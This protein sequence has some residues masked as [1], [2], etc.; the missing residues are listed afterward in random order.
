MSS[1]QPHT[2]SRQEPQHPRPRRLISL[3]LLA[4]FSALIYGYLWWGRF[5]YYDEWILGGV[6]VGCL[7]LLL[8]HLI[9]GGRRHSLHRWLGLRLDNLSQALRLAL[10]LT[11]AMAAAALVVAW[12]SGRLQPEQERLPWV[13]IPWA[14][15]Q[16]FVLQGFLLPR[17]KEVLGS[18]GAAIVA[19]AAL[20]GLYHL[21]NWP[22]MAASFL[23]G[24][25]WCWIFTRR[26][27][28][29]AVAISHALLGLLISFF[30]KFDGLQQFRVGKGGHPYDNFGAGVT[31]AA[32]YDASNQPFIAALPGPDIDHPCRVRLFRPD[33]ELLRE[34]EAFPS[35]GYSC[36]VAAGD[37]DSKPGD[38]IALA[39]GPGVR[40]PSQVRV[41]D[42]EGR[43]MERF[44]L[45]EGGYGAWVGIGRGR[46]T[47]APGPGPEAPKRVYEYSLDEGLLRTWNL[48]STD[49][50]NALRASPL[51]DPPRLLVWPTPV[52]VNHGFVYVFSSD[53][54][55]PLRWQAFNTD[56][57]L[58]LA[59]LRLQSGGWGVVTAPGAL[60]GHPPHIR[61]Y[62]W[63]GQ[64]Q[65]YFYAE[66]RQEDGCG[67]NLAAVDVD[68]DGFDEIIMADGH[69]PGAPATVRVFTQQGQL[70]HRFPAF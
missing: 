53:S 28:L 11:A 32:G 5:E 41:F 35:V 40:A 59:A 67:A 49:F 56:Y 4:L 33:G 50:V 31:L 8:V 47:A 9:L 26:P 7:C 61:L 20:F 3:L 30:F 2:A 22:L 17:C 15:L 13:Y 34:F 29:W 58:S 54:T 68:E 51:P 27:N 69:C 60:Q 36:N 38:E 65:G 18:R 23:G 1:A 14:L 39:P 63:D 64:L 66:N 37:L 46:L 57:G 55:Q 19:A 24:L 70:L 21:P 48:E 6:Y 10:P 44:V 45:P 52:S 42:L 12:A 43:E 16:Q 25:A 62:S